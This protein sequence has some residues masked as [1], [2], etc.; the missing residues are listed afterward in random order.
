MQHVNSGDN[1][2]YV[3]MVYYTQV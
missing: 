2:R 3:N 1:Y